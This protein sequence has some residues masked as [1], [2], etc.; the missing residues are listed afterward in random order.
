MPWISEFV[1]SIDEE[2]IMSCI[3]WQSDRRSAN[4]CRSAHDSAGEGLACFVVEA[5]SSGHGE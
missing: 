4:V 3:R 1:P 2:Q 5:V